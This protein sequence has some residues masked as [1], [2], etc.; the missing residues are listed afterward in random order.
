LDVETVEVDV[1][2]P[3]G[4][5]LA[6]PR[7]LRR[8]PERRGQ[9]WANFRASLPGTYRVIVR[10]DAGDEKQNLQAKIDVV[11]PNLESDN[12]R[13]N[14]KL[15][16]DLARETDGKY[17]PLEKAAAELPALLPDRGERFSVD[18]QL[19]ALWDQ[20]WVLFSLVGL[21]GCEWVVRKLLRL[22]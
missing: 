22:A 21:L 18:E 17:V 20:E 13:Q 15:L 2:D 11:L 5:P 12:P 6:A 3:H 16:A 8:D 19:R 9:Y 14:A 7:S 10:P 1:F 4:V